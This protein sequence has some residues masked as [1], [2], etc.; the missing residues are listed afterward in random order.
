MDEQPD[1]PSTEE[2]QPTRE[3][4]GPS[5]W[6]KPK[7]HWLRYGLIVLLIA[8]VA[9]VIY[10][11][12]QHPKKSTPVNTPTTNANQKTNQTVQQTAPATAH[13]DSSNFNLS[14]DYPKDWTVTDSGNNQLTVRSTN[15]NLTTASGQTITA[16]VLMT[17]APKGQNLSVF[18][19]GSAV[20]VLGSQKISYTKPT[21]NQRADT[22]LSFLQ[23]A[24]TT[25]AGALDAIDITGN[26]GYTKGQDIPKTDIA[27]IDPLVN[28][29]F[30][31][32]ASTACPAGTTT[33][34][35]IASSNWNDSLF[36][37]PITKMLESLSFN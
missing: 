13:F 37:A 26:Y 32:C 33:A 19:A 28:I 23:Y 25:A 11:L 9:G 14:F 30:L 5:Y 4:V 16:Q 21:Q 3:P 10:W 6:Q 27:G 18:N 20:A 1:N 7:R 31:K 12:W 2:S 29:S 8:V 34:T 17:I 15:M 35:S 22:Y 36:S 24:N